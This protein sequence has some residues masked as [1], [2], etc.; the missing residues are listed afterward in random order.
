MGINP[1][2]CFLGG[3]GGRSLVVI[4]GRKVVFFKKFKALFFWW[5]VMECLEKTDGFFSFLFFF[6]L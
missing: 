5:C 4:Q 6:L 2:G 3:M 1:K